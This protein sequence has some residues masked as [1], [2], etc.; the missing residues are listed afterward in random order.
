MTAREHWLSSKKKFLGLP[1]PLSWLQ[2]HDVQSPVGTQGETRRVCFLLRTVQPLG[3]YLHIAALLS[4]SLILWIPWGVWVRQVQAHR[5]REN[6]V[7]P[8]WDHLMRYFITHFHHWQ[9]RK[10]RQEGA[11][12]LLPDWDCI[13]H[14]STEKKY[15]LKAKGSRIQWL[16]P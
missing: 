12:W 13:S 14:R 2:E 5:E 10:W 6:M 9:M 4:S 15:C 8:W 16:Y 3:K 7:L 1:P 11:C